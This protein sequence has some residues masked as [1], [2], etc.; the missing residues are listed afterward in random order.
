MLILPFALRSPFL[1]SIHLVKSCWFASL[2]L[3][4]IG[5]SSFGEH[6]SL[7]RHG[8]SS[9][10]HCGDEGFPDELRSPLVIL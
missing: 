5:I 2:Y 4:N 9:T 3:L 10:D 1:H 7:K 8:S 6:Q